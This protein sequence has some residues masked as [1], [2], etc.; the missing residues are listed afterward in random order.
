MQYS[1]I[2]ERRTA[3]AFATWCKNNRI[4]FLNKKGNV[5]KGIRVRDL[6]VMEEIYYDNLICSISK[7]LPNYQ[8]SVKNLI[9][10]G[11]EIVG[12][13]RK[14]PGDEDENDRIRLLQDMINNLSERSFAQ[15]IYVSPSSC[16]SIPFFERDLKHNDNIMGKLENIRGNSQN[17]LEY[18]S[19][20]DHDICLTSIDFAGLTSRTNDI[21]QL[22]ED[23]PSIKKIA[24]DTFAISN[25]VFLF[26]ADSL[27][28]DAERTLRL[29]HEVV[30]K[31]KEIGVD[32]RNN[33]VFVDEAGFNTHMIR[34]RAWSKVGEPANVTVHKQRG[35][36]IS[37]VGCI[38]YFGTV[39]FS[40]VEPLTKTDAEKLEQE[41]ANPATKKRK[42]K[43]PEKKKPL[44]KGTTAYHIVKFLEA[45][46]DTLDKHG[47]KGFFISNI[48]R[49][50]LDK[51]DNLTSRLPGACGSVTA[52]DCQGWVRHAETFW[53][54]C[55]NKELGLSVLRWRLGWLPGGKPKECI[56]H[57]YHNWSRRH[58]FDCLH[59][60]H[61]LY[62]PRSIEDPISFLLNLLPLH[63][64]RPTASHSWFI[65]WPILCT[66]LHE[67]DY[68]FH[69]ECP[70]PPVDP[71]VKL[72]NW[73]SK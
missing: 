61:R 67:L 63:K 16:A 21:I 5:V 6:Y 59:V 54:R 57:P 4:K 65:L 69:D 32:F 42:A 49:S 40:K 68:Y 23:N 58:A 15:K 14:S 71:G 53:D 72:L 50:P 28:M 38:A 43:D 12:Y 26:D 70:P 35:A 41:Y 60:H 31:W 2:F 11:Y 1:T 36:N 27:K 3:Q 62:L 64:P 56:F 47:K 39:N 22:V 48:K 45:I 13:A 55:I 44:K 9:H 8:K 17:M 33:C 19:S 20:V 29:R 52:Q 24:I 34:G 30:S 7:Y 46:M 25:E 51:A 73:L 10:E 37:I 18:L 66:I